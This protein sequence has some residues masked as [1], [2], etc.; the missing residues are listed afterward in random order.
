MDNILV[1]HV[2]LHNN[3]FNLSELLLLSLLQLL[4]VVMGNREQD[5]PKRV[6]GR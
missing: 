5:A 6:V 3:V 4:T 1:R 2:E